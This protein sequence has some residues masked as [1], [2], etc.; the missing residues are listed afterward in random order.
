MHGVLNDYLAY[1]PM[2][3]DSSMAVAG[4][5]KMNVLFDE[6]DLARIVLNFVPSS[7]LNQYNMMHSTLHKNPRALLNDLNAIEQVMDEKHNANLKAKTKERQLLPEP[8]REVP[9]SVLP[10][11]TPVKCKS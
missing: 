11:E 8:P 4:T 6:A 3:F 10:L 1:L 9:R 5:K 2:V 7:W